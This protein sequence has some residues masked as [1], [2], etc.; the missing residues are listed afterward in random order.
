MMVLS[1]T[2]F[3]PKYVTLGISISPHENPKSSMCE[4]LLQ[5]QWT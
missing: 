4:L 1:Y 3:N 2:V 5:V